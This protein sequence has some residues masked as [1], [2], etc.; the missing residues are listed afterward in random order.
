MSISKRLLQ[1]DTILKNELAEVAAK[2]NKKMG[3]CAYF[4]DLIYR[5]V[6]RQALTPV[7]NG[8]ISLSAE[9]EERNFEFITE[10][11]IKWA[12]NK[13]IKLPL[14]KTNS[15]QQDKVLAY[16]TPL[17]EVQRKAIKQF[18][19]KYDENSPPKSEDIVSWLK[20]NHGLSNRVALAIDNIIR[21]P[22]QKAG[23]NK[24]IVHKIK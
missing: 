7:Y 8:N 12:T 3:D 19:I 13:Q 4:R 20:N 21:P 5:A 17:I 15:N 11:T 6:V 18:W 9:P 10:E 23:G 24:R 1:A 14:Q 16:T 2:Y 22:K